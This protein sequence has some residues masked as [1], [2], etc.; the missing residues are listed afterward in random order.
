MIKQ[1]NIK[2][3]VVD[4]LNAFFGGVDTNSDA[5]IREVLSELI[6][7]CRENDCALVVISHMNKNQEQTNFYRVSGSTGLPALARSIFLVGKVREEL[8]GNSYDRS[9][10]V[11]VKSNL[12]LMTPTIEFKVDTEGNFEWLEQTSYDERDIFKHT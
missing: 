9:F 5:Q 2:M 8:S 3:L 4:P 7:S 12:G 1:K 10:L 11:H 6:L